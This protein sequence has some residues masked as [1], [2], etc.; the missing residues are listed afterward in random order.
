M[1]RGLKRWNESPGHGCPSR[2]CCSSG[3]VRAGRGSG[4]RAVLVGAAERQPRGEHPP[5]IGLAAGIRADAASSCERG[6]CDRVATRAAEAARVR[7][8]AGRHRPGGAGSQPARHRPDAE[9]R[10][11][12]AHRS[13]LPDQPG[14]R[15]AALRRPA[16]DRRR[17][18]GRRLGGRGRADPGQGPLDPHAQHRLRLH[19]PRRRRPGLQQG[20]HDRAERRTSSTAVPGCGGMDG[21]S[22]TD[23]YLPAPGRAADPELRPLGHPDRQERRPDADRQR[24]LPA[25]TS[26][27]ACTP[28]PSTPSSGAATWSSASPP[29]QGAGAPGRGRPGPEHARRPG[30]AGRL[31]APGV[32][33]GQRQPDPG[34]AARP[35]RGGRAAGARPRPDHPDRPRPVARR[36]DADRPDQPPRAGLLTRRSSRR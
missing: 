21:I 7:P 10:A 34:A 14:D 18:A 25:C 15:A 19:P 3:R 4:G 5:P 33:G 13:P 1:E 23:A 22:T 29:E 31:G 26:T 20:H 32:A 27:A 2:L 8:R 9:A 28:A 36:P 6:E 30:A 17:R 11:A 12:G 24:L 16:A 35:P